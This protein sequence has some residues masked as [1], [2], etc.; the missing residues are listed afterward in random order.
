MKMKG[1]KRILAA[2][3]IAIGLMLMGSA[4]AQADTLVFELSEVFSSDTP[5]GPIPY[6]TA[7]LEDTAPGE[8]TIF[9]D[10][11]NLVNDEFVG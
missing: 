1:T 11:S 10:G 3:V 7:T 9:L 5:G 4:T 6:L 2:L 8:V